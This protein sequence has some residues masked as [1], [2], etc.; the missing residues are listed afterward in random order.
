MF[1]EI[2]SLRFALFQNDGWVFCHCGGY[3]L[4]LPL[5]LLSPCKSIHLCPYS[6]PLRDELPVKQNVDNALCERG[7]KCLHFLWLCQDERA[8]LPA[9]ACPRAMISLH[10]PRQGE[11]LRWMRWWIKTR[12]SQKFRL[13][14]KTQTETLLLKK[15]CKDSKSSRRV[16]PVTP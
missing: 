3:D 16:A 13:K 14:Q 12:R 2:L 4:P 15:S 8:H 10:C 5:P 6:F 7:G 9:R 11:R 1:F